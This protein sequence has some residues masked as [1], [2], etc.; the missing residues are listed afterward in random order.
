MASEFSRY[1]RC[2]QGLQNS[3]RARMQLFGLSIL[4]ELTLPRNV[5]DELKSLYSNKMVIL[6]Y[7]TGG[8]TL[9]ALES[10]IENFVMGCETD[11]QWLA[12]LSTEI[13]SR[14][15]SNRFLPVYQDIGKTTEWGYPCFKEDKYTQ[16]R[17]RQFLNAPTLPWHILKKRNLAPD[18]VFIDGRFRVASFIATF[19]NARQPCTIIFD[20][21]KDRPYYHIVERLIKPKKFIDRTAFFDFRPSIDYEKTGDFINTFLPYYSSMA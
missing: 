7:G 11:G 12:R 1:G 18:V 3:Q 14:N 19:L 6:E 17:G 20:D 16:E 8:S 15:L 13:V 5:A 10:N 21:Y 9:L 4:F 2:K